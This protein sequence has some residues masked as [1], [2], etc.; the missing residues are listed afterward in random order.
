MR[1][2]DMWKLFEKVIPI[3]H[4]I[5]E[6]ASIQSQKLYTK[7]TQY[8][9]FVVEHWEMINVQSWEDTNLTRAIILGN[10]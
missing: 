3:P 9:R 8:E 5:V 10:I 7:C 2:I 6:T 4:L 1:R